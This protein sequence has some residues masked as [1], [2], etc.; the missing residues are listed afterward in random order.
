MADMPTDFWS[1]WIALVTVISLVGLAWLVFSVYFS[2]EGQHEE[3]P[4]WDETLSEGSNPAPMWWF[5]LILVFLVF[6]VA[7]LMLY[8]GLGSYKGALK[9]SQGGRLGESFALYDYEFDS[10][11]QNVLESSLQDLQ[12]NP[13]V[14][15]SAAGIFSRNC[16][17]CHGPKAK[18][19]AD[20]FPNL[21]DEAWQ[22][23]S[24]PAQ[25]EQTIRAG[26]QAA[27][28]AWETVLGKEG[29]EH[30]SAYVLSIS[31]AGSEHP[32]AIQFQQFCSA[33]HGANGKGNAMLGAP[34]LTDADWLYGIDAVAHSIATG[35]NG[36]MPAFGD[37]LDDVQVR[38]L[39]AWLSKK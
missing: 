12:A 35:R 20:M 26:R 23:G 8:P 11:R 15:M 37:R 33:C 30:V 32:G 27:M 6:S 9:W 38:M 19:Q 18:G 1:G 17:A 3:S 2:P 7:Y 34:D 24:E 13:A 10:I 36:Q 39:V 4:V 29:V 22:W 21:R 28:P 31:T 25:I 5:W 14:M 16:A